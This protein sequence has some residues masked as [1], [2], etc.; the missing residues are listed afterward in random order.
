MKETPIYEVSY[1]SFEKLIDTKR[2]VRENKHLFIE[3][4]EYDNISTNGSIT[5]ITISEDSIDKVILDGDLY[6]SDFILKFY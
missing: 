5:K 6:N 4:G 1:K 2:V 3:P